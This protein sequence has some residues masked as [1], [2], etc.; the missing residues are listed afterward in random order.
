MV[1]Y[2][3]GLATPKLVDYL[4]FG[5]D[6]QDPPNIAFVVVC[7]NSLDAG[8]K[9]TKQDVILEYW[10]TEMI[11]KSAFTSLQEVHGRTLN[12][13]MFNGQAVTK[14]DLQK[15]ENAAE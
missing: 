11:P 13:K 5:T 10:P 8:K 1:A 15:S 14:V 7:T 3:I 4:R 2:A 6:E 12:T 9:I